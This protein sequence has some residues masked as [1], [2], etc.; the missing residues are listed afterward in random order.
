MFSYGTSWKLHKIIP[1]ICLNFT[2]CPELFAIV[3]AWFSCMIMT[4][5]VYV[6]FFCKI[7]ITSFVSA[8]KL[9]SKFT[10]P[11]KRNLLKFSLFLFNL[12]FFFFFYFLKIYNRIQFNFGLICK[13][14]DTILSIF[15]GV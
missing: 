4:N 2:A 7:F 1:I 6:F 3:E 8:S 13:T 10:F 12:I 15:N 5:I 11:D 14:I 9:T